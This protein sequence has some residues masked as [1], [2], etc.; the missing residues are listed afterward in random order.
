MQL[1]SCT[2]RSFTRSLDSRFSTSRG[3]HSCSCRINTVKKLL[4][5]LTSEADQ[6]IMNPTRKTCVLDLL[7]ERCA[8]HA[9][10]SYWKYEVLNRWF[11]ET[12]MIDAVKDGIT[13]EQLMAW[14]RHV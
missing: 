12:F 6:K 10:L 14:V 11:S 13:G 8:P 3:K 2:S 7:S 9:A 5:E 1:I 4:R